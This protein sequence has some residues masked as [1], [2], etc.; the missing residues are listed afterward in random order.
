MQLEHPLKTEFIDSI[1]PWGWDLSLKRELERMG[2]PDIML[3]TDDTL[4]KVRTI[5]SRQWAAQHLQQGVVYADSCAKV[6]A[7]VLQQGKAVVKAPWSSAAG[8]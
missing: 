7:L 4:N 1:H 5:S 3:P 2:V 8:A 6:K